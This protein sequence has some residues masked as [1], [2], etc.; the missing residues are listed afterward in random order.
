MADNSVAP[1]T[2]VIHAADALRMT[3]DPVV[4]AIYQTATFRAASAEAYAELATEERHHAFYS[5]YG[6]PTHLPA[7]AIIAALEG[8]EACLVFASGMAAIVAAL[9]TYLSA[10]DHAIV[11][12]EHYSG[13]TVFVRDHLRRFGINVTAVNQTDVANIQSAIRQNT[14]LILVETP[15]NPSLHITDLTAVA[16]IARERGILTIADNTVATPLNQ[17]PLAHGIDLVVHSATKYLAGHSDLSAGVIAGSEQHV[18]EVWQTARILGA[19]LAPLDSWLLHR[20]LR[21]LGI[22]MESHNRN[23]LAVARF[24]ES[25][26]SVKKVYYPGLHC[27]PQYEIAARQMS[28]FSGLLSLELQSDAAG[29]ERFISSLQ[30]FSRAASLGGVESLVVQPA[31]MHAGQMSDAEFQ[32]VGVSQNLI[33]LSIGIEGLDDLLSDL[34]VALMK[35]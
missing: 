14:R 1:Q 7:E 15:S 24:L 8:A 21:T 17:K 28:G 2:K 34:D 16:A 11:Q 35:V 23:G 3:A 25:A 27:H 4:P 5:R 32:A 26:S 22:R 9:L 31:A 29:A 10:G 13:T 30:L 12:K 18:R 20:G 33:R 19:V 6:N